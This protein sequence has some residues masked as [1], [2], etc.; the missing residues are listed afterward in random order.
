VAN[1]GFEVVNKEE[2]FERWLI[3]SRR[4]T[5]RARVELE[6]NFGFYLD[7]DCF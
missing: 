2:K 1:S 4:A 3:I 6:M 7:G 5:T